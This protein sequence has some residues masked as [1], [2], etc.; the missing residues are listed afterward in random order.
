ML[1]ASGAVQG[2][3]LRPAQQDLR[4]QQSR[5]TRN[6]VRNRV[7]SLSRLLAALLLLQVVLAPALC[8]AHAAQIAAGEAVQ[9]CTVDGLRVVHLDADGQEQ[10][11][12]ADSGHHGFCPL[13]HAL[14]EAASVAAPVLPPPGWT[15]VE[16]AWHAPP[17]AAPPPAIRGPPSGARAPPTRLS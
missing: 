6:L 9:I 4:T 15:P 12:P 8:M 2:D 16:V 14:P 11:P 3:L 5:P 1:A 10:A 17:M 13:C 7:A